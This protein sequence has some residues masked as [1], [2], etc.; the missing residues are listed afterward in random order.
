VALPFS[1]ITIFLLTIAMRARRNKV[2][3]GP[4][5]MIGETGSAVTDLTPEGMV[6][7]HGEYWDAVAVRPTVAGAAIRV[8]AIHQ[9]RLR[10]EP[11]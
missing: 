1:A 11:V 9:L 6:F 7:V 8:T 10:V 2:V 3:T 5:G 4:E